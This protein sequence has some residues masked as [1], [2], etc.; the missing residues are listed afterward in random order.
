VRGRKEEATFQSERRTLLP[1]LERRDDEDPSNAAA[2]EHRVAHSD[3][4]I[5]G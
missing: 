3:G 2:V 1:S 4:V 5:D